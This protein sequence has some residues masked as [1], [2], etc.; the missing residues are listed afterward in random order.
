MASK[1][2]ASVKSA[3]TSKNCMEALASAVVKWFLLLILFVY[4]AASYMITK[5]ASYCG[6]NTPCL[7]CSR[8]DHVFS[9]KKPGYYWDMICGHHKTELSSLV[10]CHAHDKLADVH[11]MCESCLF[12]FATINESNAETYRLFVGHVSINRDTWE[13]TAIEQFHEDSHQK[14]QQSDQLTR[15]AY[16]KLK[17]NSD[18]ESEVLFSEDE[19]EELLLK[20]EKPQEKELGIQRV[21]T[22]PLIEIADPCFIISSSALNAQIDRVSAHDDSVGD[23][24]VEQGLVKTTSIDKEVKETN[25]GLFPVPELISF[26]DMDSIADKAAT[27]HGVVAEEGKSESFSFVSLIICLKVHLVGFSNF[28]IPL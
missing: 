21:P 15:V 24:F 9:I 2:V 16:I 23:S 4:A 25:V 13:I 6:L 12:L 27:P 1:R 10:L 26:T 3:T 11:Q 18:A 14:I 5:F 28:G 22:D 7:L 8:L 17:I 20:T 19:A